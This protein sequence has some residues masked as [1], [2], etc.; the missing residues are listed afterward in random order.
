MRQLTLADVIGVLPMA[1]T[2]SSTRLMSSLDR[3]TV[4][5]MQ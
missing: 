4:L 3:W 1:N 2:C 5:W